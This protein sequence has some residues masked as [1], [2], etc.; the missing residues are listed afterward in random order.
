MEP[1]VIKNLNFKAGDR[2]QIVHDNKVVSGVVIRIYPGKNEIYILWEG[3]VDVW[4]YDLDEKMFFVSCP[5]N[6]FRERI[7][8]RV[9]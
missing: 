9:K 8:E 5:Y 1:I 6:D 3:Q 4:W 7:R 2:V